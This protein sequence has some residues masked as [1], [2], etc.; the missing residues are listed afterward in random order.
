MDEYILWIIN[1]FD[2]T[3]LEI[4]KEMDYISMIGQI[5]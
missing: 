4:N 1:L 5:G 2:A 3:S